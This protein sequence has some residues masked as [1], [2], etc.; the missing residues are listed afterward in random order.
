M[1]FR[2]WLYKKTGIRLKRFA[3]E[4]FIIE[5]KEFLQFCLI[6]DIQIDSGANFQQ[7]LGATLG[8]RSK[9]GAHTYMGPGSELLH[10]SEISRYCSVASNACLGLGPHP[11]NWLSTH[12]FQFNFTTNLSSGHDPNKKD[13]SPKVGVTIGN[14]VWIGRGACIMSGVTIGDGVIIGAG[15][16]VTKDVP[17]YA[18]V[19]GV[20]AKIIRYRFDEPTIQE[21]LNLKWWELEPKDMQGIDFDDVHKAIGQI[22]CIKLQ[23][24]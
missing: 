21:L 19:G 23:Q 1:G 8:P 9:I 17:P 3:N 24:K 6:N 12:P 10:D 18:I 22:R 2:T 4:R 7:F 16:V 11:I 20:P 13:Y 15:S 5:Q 14:D